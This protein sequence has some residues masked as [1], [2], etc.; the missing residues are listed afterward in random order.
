MDN[1]II[2]DETE[3][4]MKVFKKLAKLY[5]PP[6]NQKDAH[7]WE[8]TQKILRNPYVEDNQKIII[9]ASK[10]RFFVFTYPS[11]GLKVKGLISFVPHPESYPTLFVLRGGNRIFGLLNPSTDLF[12]VRNYTTISTLY[13]DGVS[14]GIDE[15]GG[16]DV[17]DVKNL[18]EFLPQLEKNLSIHFQRDKMDMIGC[19]RGG[20]QLFLTLA[21]FPKLRKVLKKVVSLSGLLDL[22]HCIHSRQDMK[23]MFEDDFGLK[24][25]I[26]EEEWLKNRDPLNVAD[27]IDRTLPILIIQGTEDIRVDLI[28]GYRMMK[29]LLKNGCQVTYWE[30]QGA[31]HCLDNIKDRMLR[32]VEW[33]ES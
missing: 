7:I 27:K 6:S 28:E 21:R 18:I 12:C 8:I 11:D 20:M 19:S 26:N 25:G 24:A 10:R 16:Q 1:A 23:K 14:E 4:M 32:I 33:L 31:N 13:R 2:R 5:E 22:Q 3:R 17:N 30:I 15:Y 9:Q 29:R